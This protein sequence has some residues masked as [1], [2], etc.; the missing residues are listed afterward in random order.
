MFY[1]LKGLYYEYKFRAY[2]KVIIKLQ[3]ARDKL[4][5][6]QGKATVSRE[7][8]SDKLAAHKAK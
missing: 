2:E 1:I 3:C 5:A 6:K 4:K 8:Y 7:K